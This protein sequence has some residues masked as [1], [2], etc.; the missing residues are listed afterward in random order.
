MLILLLT[1]KIV[2]MKLNLFSISTL[3]LLSMHVNAQNS[4]PYWSLAG[5]NNVTSSSKFGTTNNYSVRFYTNNTQRMI[6]NSPAGLV[7]IGTTTPTDQLHVNSAVGTNPLRVQVNGYTKLFVHSAGGVAIGATATPPA[8]GLYV[9]GNVGIGTKTPTAKLQVSGNASIASGL[10]VEDYGIVGLN[11][12]GDGVVGSSRGAA[13]VYGQSLGNGV[14]GDAA[15]YGVYGSGGGRGVGGYSTEGYGGYFTSD[16]SYGLVAATTPKG[17]Y[18]GAFYGN[19]YTSGTLYQSSD[20]NLKTN[21]QEFGDAMSI[22]NKLKP[23]NYE[24]KKDKKLASLNLPAGSHY[25]LL[26]QDLQEVLPNLVS[27]TPHELRTI[28]PVITTKQTA[29][30]KTAHVISDEKETKEIIKIKGVNYLELIPILVKGMQ[31]LSKENEDLKNQIVDLKSLILKNGN[32][33]TISS[34]SGYIK[35]NA[36]NP[37]N[38]STIISYY[39]PNETRNAQILVTDI[40]GSV[41][42]AYN[43]S[44]GEGQVNI[45]SG[46]FASGTYNY[47]LYMNNNKIDTK[48][49]I[50][51]K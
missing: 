39:I 41:L 6:I 42:R 33:S 12:D 21:I 32:S 46:E 8:N 38:N 48:Q 23:K 44:R 49:M 15:G 36:P 14:V 47:T 50:I 35:Q 30:G 11:S 17:F 34:L 37:S 26:A 27:E 25:G 51:I 7:G 18:A 16:S 22:I 45:K 5:N 13:G 28:K 31:E 40:K 19:V 3:I 29:D 10:R 24:F 20:K 2:A 1:F 43:V 4:S 9:S